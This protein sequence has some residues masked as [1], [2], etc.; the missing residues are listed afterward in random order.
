MS[1]EPLKDNENVPT[2]TQRIKT[3][4]CEKRGGASEEGG[5]KRETIMTNACDN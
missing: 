5:E 1:A 3:R 4:V 2:I